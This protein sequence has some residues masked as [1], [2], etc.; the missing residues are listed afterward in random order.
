MEFKEY[1]NG[2]AKY[3]SELN[4]TS[5]PLTTWDFYSEFFDT[6]KKSVSDACLLNKI[7]TTNQ[8]KQKWNINQKLQNET[9]IVV[10]CPKLKIVF[11]SQNILKMNG[12][13][14]EEVIGNS[15]K[16]FQGRLTD[17][18]VSSEIGAAVMAQQPFEKVVVNY[19][20]DGSLY[21]CL[22]K[23]FPIFNAKGEL[24]NFIAFEKAA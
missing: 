15:P 17:S 2:V 4:I 3:F 12:Y 1:E 13:K 8:W 9:V 7:A 5:M 21:K 14:P 23:G 10:T 20:K 6:T 18:V 16:M 11:A 24:T 22:I 19:R